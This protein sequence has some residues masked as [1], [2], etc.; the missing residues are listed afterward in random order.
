MK[1]P[2][3]QTDCWNPECGKTTGICS[4]TQFPEQQTPPVAIEKGSDDE[5][6]EPYFG[7]CDVD[8]CE[9]ESCNNGTAWSK[10]GYWKVC[11]K[12]SAQFRN[13][14]P[15]PTMKQKSVDRENSRLEDGTLPSQPQPP[16]E[17]KEVELLMDTI[18][19]QHELILSGEKRGYEKAKEEFQSPKPD[20]E[21]EAVEFAEWAQINYWEINDDGLWYKW[22]PIND[23][24]NNNKIITTTELYQLFKNKNV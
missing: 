18:K 22:M 9:N 16:I 7:W 10:S 1:C 3:T 11:Y 17:N 23:V 8:G 2:R 20:A 24:N 4:P 5:E 14:L 12:H 15:Q 6:Y 13:G 21:K 19:K